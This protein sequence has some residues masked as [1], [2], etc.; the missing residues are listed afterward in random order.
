MRRL[1]RS[2]GADSF[3][4]RHYMHEEPSALAGVFGGFKSTNSMALTFD[5]SQEGVAGLVRPLVS[6]G[7]IVG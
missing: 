1:R 5:E 2:A 7:G 3:E 6:D 4:L